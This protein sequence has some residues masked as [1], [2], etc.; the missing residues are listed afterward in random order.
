MTTQD[1]TGD[2]RRW[3]ALPILLAG[4]F[5]PSLDFFIVNV[6]LP[7][8]RTDLHATPAQVQFVISAYAATYAVFL[9]SGGR[10]GDLFGRRRLFLSGINGFTLASM[11]CGL[12]WSPTALIAGRM[13]QGI[14]AAAMAPQ[15]LASIRVMFPTAEQPRA[16]GLYTATFGIAATL[17]QLLGGVLVSSHLWGF[18]WQLIFLV[19][20]PV[21]IA[22][23]IGGSLLLRESRATQAQRLDLG[24]VALLSLALGLLVYPLVEGREQGWPMWTFV[25]LGT[26]LLAF[27]AF[28]RYEIRI[29]S[30][31]GAPLV[32]VS[33]LRGND[34]VLGLVIT[35]CFYMISAFFLTFAAYLEDG[36]HHNALQTGIATVPFTIGFFLASLGS[37]RAVERFGTRAL[38]MSLVAQALGFGLTV[39]SV[40][41]GSPTLGL[42]S[43]LLIAGLGYGIGLPSLIKI[44]I[45]G[46]DSRHAGLASGM[47]ITV[48]Q[49]SAALGVAIIGGVFYSALGGHDDAHAYTHAFSTGLYCNIAVLLLTAL[50]SLALG[51]TKTTTAVGAPAVS[52]R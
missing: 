1:A 29:A 45:G 47:V 5:L 24:G 46:M 9:I 12:A 14:T 7:A 40:Q 2:P 8:I 23:I 6:A 16:L 42:I 48:L 41:N 26:S 18:G 3:L 19:N 10:L 39:T 43:G 50:L 44:V 31:G 11:L 21:G 49:I 13:L 33:L 22:A 17:G 52:R 25:M 28:V 36:L 35:L 32:D 30:H 27:V 34:F 4:A 15:V 37:A 20:L 51:S 38:T